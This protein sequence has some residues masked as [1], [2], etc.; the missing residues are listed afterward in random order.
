MTRA[1]KMY[2]SF[3][4]KLWC[5]WLQSRGHKVI[6][7]ISFPDEWEEDY[8]IEGW[9][10]HSVIAISSVGVLT[11][12]NP[13]EW[14]KAVKR[15]REELQPIHI[16]RYGPKIPDENE[17]NCTYFTNDNNRSANGR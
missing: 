5:A 9:P 4:N 8:W 15:I 6:P 17:E 1:Q 10:V 14:L 13:K 16:L 3:L 7:N 12:G 2:S 11:H